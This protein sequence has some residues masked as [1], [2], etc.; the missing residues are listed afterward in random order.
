MK[1]R[2]SAPARKPLFCPSG[3]PTG[4]LKVLCRLAWV[5]KYLLMLSLVA[6]L[7]LMTAGFP[8][9]ISRSVETYVQS[10]GLELEYERLRLN[11]LF[12]LVADEVRIQVNGLDHS[13]D[14]YAETLQINLNWIG[15][16]RKQEWIQG[17]MIR[18]GT[19]DLQAGHSSSAPVQGH[20]FLGTNLQAFVSFDN[21]GVQIS[22]GEVDGFGQH[23]SV[24]GILRK[25][26][27]T[28]HPPVNLQA[29]WEQVQTKL[30]TA[31]KS[32]DAWQTLHLGEDVQTQLR[33]DVSPGD[34]V[35]SSFVLHAQG[36]SP[37]IR[38]QVF[39][40]WKLDLELR[41]A[42]LML[43]ELELLAADEK[44]RLEGQF[45]FNVPTVSAHVYSTLNP[46]LI[47]SVLPDDVWKADILSAELE[48]GSLA[49]EAWMGPV[50]PEEWTK[51]WKGWVKLAEIRLRE[52]WIEEAFAV[53]QWNTPELKL[54]SIQALLGEGTDQGVFSGD[55]VIPIQ[56]HGGWSAQVHTTL[57][58]LVLRPV[59]PKPL[60]KLID[61]FAFSE[62]NPVTDLVLDLRW[63]DEHPRLVLN[64]PISG[65]NFS[66]NGVLLQTMHAQLAYEKGLVTLEG[67]EATRPDGNLSGWLDVDTRNHRAAF[68]FVSSMDLL[69]LAGLVGRPVEQVVEAIGANA[70][71]NWTAMGLLDLKL[72]ESD[73]TVHFQGHDAKVLRLNFPQADVTCHGKD[74]FLL[75]T[76]HP[77]SFYGGTL[78]GKLDAEFGRG[79]VPFSMQYQVRDSKL[80]GLLSLAREDSIPDLSGRVSGNV[81]LKGQ[82]KD[83]DLGNCTG[84]GQIQIRE[85]TLFRLPLLGGLS[86]LLSMIIPGLG[87]A[88]QT[89]M[90][91]S[92]SLADGAFQSED[93][94]IKGNVVSIRASGKYRL[95][96]ELDFDVQAKPLGEGVLADVLQFITTPIS[97][98]LEFELRG[99]VD[100]PLWRAR[101]WP[102][103][104]RF[105]E[106]KK[107]E[108]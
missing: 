34:L 72:R 48:K 71:G 7:Y 59:A 26:K 94:F 91:A 78:T 93:L 65:E 12:G 83:F 51:A 101:H 4:L 25:R 92:F 22:L 46:A 13:V 6:L 87:Y 37:Q 56:H 32:L 17:L 108:P 95:N 1:E 53:L 29:L 50:P 70:R 19:V 3:K 20:S 55:L 42:T 62:S 63:E 35:N 21:E 102:D 8:T 31:R 81:D 30:D 79:T 38:S 28:G 88:S 103:E 16:W 68:D 36:R 40:D 14:L 60:Q 61:R 33:F 75:F 43:N 104:L 45:R 5:V 67:I 64:G 73:F 98:L 41:D 84:G 74:A 52:I 106:G 107:V 85:G 66:Y 100:D 97:K 18:G 86:R 57:D 10:R 2:S 54:E 44:V 76:I 69:P 82:F 90:E 80:E 23:M 58:P 9:P 39:D 105:R 27:E 77:S 11:V 24:E 15:W 89:D 96:R 49:L 99:T 47:Q